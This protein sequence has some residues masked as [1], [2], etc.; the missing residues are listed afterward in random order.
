[1]LKKIKIIFFLMVIVLVTGFLVW[2]SL[3]VIV[4]DIAGAKCV[5][6]YDE[7]YLYKKDYEPFIVL[8]FPGSGTGKQYKIWILPDQKQ[9]LLEKIK[10]D[11]NA[12]LTNAIKNNGD[13]IKGY[14]ISDDFKKVYIYYC[15][16][17]SD[18]PNSEFFNRVNALTH[19]LSSVTVGRKVELY[20]EFINGIGKT[21]FH[22]YIV[23]FVEIEE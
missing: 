8:N 4:Q 11:V 19:E 20:H 1:M 7:F 6:D 5:S 13:I 17:T 2:N 9:K 15:K 23:N 14:E 21:E 10:E 12:E 18:E 16:K 3:S 22:G